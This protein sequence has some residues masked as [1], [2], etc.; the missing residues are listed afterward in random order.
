MTY[1]M[2]SLDLK[3]ADDDQRKDFYHVLNIDDWVKLPGVDTVWQKKFASIISEPSIRLSIAADL[4][5]AAG[6][7]RIK[8]VTFAAQIGNRVAVAGRTEKVP[9]GYK[10]I[11]K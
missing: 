5:K 3:D 2:L 10:T 9:G 11:I 6:A 4:E 7:S 8:L 1:C